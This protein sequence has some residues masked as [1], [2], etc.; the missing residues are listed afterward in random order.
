MKYTDVA[1]DFDGTLV[2]TYPLLTCVLRE[3]LEQ[4]GY[5]ATTQE[6]HLKMTISIRNAIDYYAA[7]L[8]IEPEKLS[9][10]YVQL[11][12]EKG[13][14]LDAVMV[15]PGVPEVLKAIKESGGRN[16]LYTNR[17]RLAL[18]YLEAFDL[19]QYFDG[20]ITAEN[21][22]RLK[23]APDGMYVL[24]EQFQIKPERMLMVGDRAVDI[25]AAKA[26]GTDACFY[27]TNGI[28]TP[29]GRDF[30]INHIKELLQYL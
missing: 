19:L 10:Q 13:L 27:N 28:E 15:Y 3:L 1:W 24:L 16:H 23:P 22:G 2:D 21:I 8:G 29:A 14:C 17:N 30:E 25:D 11:R 12:T 7:E 5:V 20:F 18:E 4:Y 9:E 6:I 26:A